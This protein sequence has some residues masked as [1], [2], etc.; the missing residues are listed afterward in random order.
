MMPVPKRAMVLAAGLGLRM[1]P[2]TDALPKALVE[3]AGKTLLDRTLDRLA[4]AGVERAVV[5]LHH[6]G[7]MIR[8][9]L[10]TRR[11]PEVVFSDESEALLETGGGI[12]RALEL[13]G[14]DPFLAVNG[15]VL[16]LDG[17]RNTLELLASR[18]DDQ[19][20]DALLLAQPT[21]GAVGYEGRGDY[22]MAPDGRLRR[23]R[24]LEMAPFLFA[25]IQILHPRL[26]DGAPAGG[27]SLNLLYD[28]A[29]GAGRL[30]GQRHEGLWAHVG[31]PQGVAEAAAVLSGL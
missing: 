20:T 30:F 8:R 3:V 21:V 19:A 24:H 9:H 28:R 10:A 4:E 11:A 14:H 16:W 6:L 5:N 1:R 25:G 27:F 2:L 31:S 23:R 13:L 29:E 12:A 26:F 15:D 22:F 18:W 17:A 7:G